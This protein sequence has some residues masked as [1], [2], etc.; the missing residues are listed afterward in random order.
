L[1]K[2]MLFIYNPMAGKEQIKNKLSDIIQ[3]LCGG[4]FEVTIF[5]TQG[6][7]DATDIV[8][9]RGEE[10]DYVVCSG[11]DG[12]MNEV[13]SGLMSLERRPICG[14]IPA[15][16]VNDFASSLKIPKVMKK[17][18]KLI[19]DGS[20]FQ[21]D[22]GQFNDRYFT[23]VSGFGAFTE[24]S[25]QTPQEWKNTLGKAAYFIEALKHIPDI[26]THHM[27]ITYDGNT[28]EDNFILGL[29]S[30]SV[31]VAGYKA[32]SKMAIMMDDG[33]FEALFIKEIR[34]PLELQATLNALMSKKFDTERIFRFSSSEITIASDDDV[35]WT[36]DGED[37]GVCRE[38]TMKNHQYALPILCDKQVSK[39]VSQRY[40]QAG[41]RG[42]IN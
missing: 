6:K 19:V 39:N 20:V 15:G 38:V 9:E 7:G 17:A 18:A 1:K 31:S 21:C 26:K 40:L 32:Y 37:G 34:N 24:V 13:A 33:L 12:T 42:N 4:G 29:V 14:Y 2:K 8:I 30:N 41:N 11:G 25:Y 23:Y 5:A 3:V 27:K 10:F 16:T 35:Q 28:I 22:M 36:L